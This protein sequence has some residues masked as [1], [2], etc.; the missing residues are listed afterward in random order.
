MVVESLFD[1]FGAF[2]PLGMLL[3]L[4]VI[5]NF[6]GIVFPVLPE[7]FVVIT[8]GVNPSIAWGTLV[9]T[10][11]VIGGVTANAAL[12]LIASKAKLPKWM[13]N[14]MKGYISML[15][16]RDERIILLNRIVPVVPYTGA[17]IA[18]CDWD[19]SR[20]IS[21]V[22]LG[23]LMKYSVLILVSDAFFVFYETGLA[24]IVTILLV[25][26]FIGVSFLISLVYRRRMKEGTL[27]N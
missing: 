24:R 13:R 22:A 7:L 14:R 18:A 23:G 6:D 15:M 21:Y 3:A 11:A 27:T 8:F 1:F 9:L 4:F 10:I 12:Y 20:S 2:G 5:F 19:V 17:F 16:V 26:L 25:I